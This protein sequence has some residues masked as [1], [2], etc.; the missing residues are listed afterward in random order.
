[1][2]HTFNFSSFFSSRNPG[3]DESSFGYP[4]H[5]GKYVNSL[6]PCCDYA[7]SLLSLMRHA[8]IQWE[9]HVVLSSKA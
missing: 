9:M 5:V 2:K 8:E 3:A 7:E 6:E 4:R 1:M